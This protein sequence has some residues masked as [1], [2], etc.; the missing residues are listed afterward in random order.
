MGKLNKKEIKE[1][2]E[3]IKGNLE[4]DFIENYNI[5]KNSLEDINEYIRNEV[6]DML[7][8]SFFDNNLL[9]TYDGLCQSSLSVIDK[10]KI[11]SKRDVEPNKLS[12]IITNKVAENKISKIIKTHI[13]DNKFY[14][15]HNYQD[16]I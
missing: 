1:V 3:S 15:H 5:W 11:K 4:E 2:R 9:Y 13:E 6:E 12:R 14:N 10:I 7:L 16:I 8:V